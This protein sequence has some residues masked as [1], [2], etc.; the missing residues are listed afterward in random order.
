MGARGCGGKE[1]GVGT[2]QRE[3]E[4]REQWLGWEKLGEGVRWEEKKR[5]TKNHLLNLIWLAL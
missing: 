2:E 3:M 1:G 4:E 5:Q